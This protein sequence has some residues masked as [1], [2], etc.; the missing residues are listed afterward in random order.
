MTNGMV[1]PYVLSDAFVGDDYLLALYLNQTG[2][3]G[4]KTICFRY[5]IMNLVCN[6]SMF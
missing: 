1:A 3:R 2:V 4:F 5:F 6:N